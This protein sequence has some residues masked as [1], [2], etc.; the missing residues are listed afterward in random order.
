MEKRD[1]LH[2]APPYVGPADKGR[3]LAAMQAAGYVPDTL[4]STPDR[5]RFFGP[6]GFVLTMAGWNECSQWLSGVVFDDPHISDLVDLFLHPERY[7]EIEGPKENLRAAED[8][9]EQNDN[10]LDGILNNLPPQEHAVQIPGQPAVPDI[11]GARGS[12]LEELE[13]NRK[14]ARPGPRVET[15]RHSPCLPGN[16]EVQQHR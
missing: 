2:A 3:L 4:E 6:G 12:V 13:N 5:L 11:R 10:S 1:E 15:W 7:R 14:N 8:M 9:L 16:K